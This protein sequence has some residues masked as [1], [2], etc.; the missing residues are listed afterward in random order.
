[1]SY[2]LLAG[3]VPLVILAVSSFDT[4]RRIIIQQAGQFHSQQMADLNAYLT[5]YA[6]QIESLSANIA[7]NESIGSALSAKRAAEAVPSGSFSALKTQAQIGY[8]LNSYVG[9]KGL[10]SIDL[11]SFDNRRFHVGDTLDVSEVDK[12]HLSALVDQTR[13]FDAPVYWF[14]IGDNLNRA[15]T[16]KKVL[17]MSR[18][19][20]YFEP[21]TGRAEEVGLLV[22]NI[23]AGVAV[24]SFLNEANTNHR[25]RLMLVDRNGNFIYHSDPSLLGANA[26]PALAKLLTSGSTSQTVRLDQEDVILSAVP[27]LRFGGHLAGALPRSDLIAPTIKLIYTGVALFLLGLCAIG[28]LSWRFA[29]HVVA[30]VRD[31]S[32]GFLRLQKHPDSSPKPLKVPEFKD[33]M[34]ELVI[35][36]NQYLE[37]LAAQRVAAQQLFVA[38]QAANAAAELEKRNLALS[39]EI[40]RREAAES[41][42]RNLAFFDQLT[43]LPN[44]RLLVDRLRQAMAVATRTKKYCALLFIDL[45]NF[46]TL[47]D[48]QGHNVGDLL[49]IEVS[50]R[51]SSCVREGDTVARQ[52]GDE[53]VV[54]LEDLSEDR[55]TAA[56]NAELV[57]EKILTSLNMTYELSRQP[58]HGTPSIGIT[59]FV[60]HEDAS[61]ELL[62]RAD[63]AMYQAKAAGRNTV[64]FFDAEMQT[65]IETR[66]AME[67]RLREAILTNQFE[68]YYQPQVANENSLIGAEVLIRWM[69]PKRGMVCPAEF[70]PLAEETGLILP[71]GSWVLETACAQLA[72]WSTQPKMADLTI[73]VNISARQFRSQSFTDEVLAIIAKTGAN[74]ARLKL[75]LTES[76]LLD[77]VESIIVNLE[78]LRAR[79]VSFSLDDFGTGYSSLSYLKRLPLD[80]LKIDQGFVRDVLVDVN[81]AAIAKMIVALAESLGLLV[82]AEGVE[83]E[84]QKQ[85]LSENGCHAFQGYLFGKPMPL[86]NFEQ[87]AKQMMS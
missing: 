33:E 49:L 25:L 7:G 39:Q 51:L 76:F 84:A 4:S 2:L 43:G 17:M 45:D 87:L 36:F 64:R 81:D 14:G 44:R 40:A 16:K 77:N 26:A 62:K 75:E 74:P 10:V 22:I 58:Y 11:F 61:E 6:E 65:A 50:R 28:L 48:T 9:V 32:M 63:L 21:S 86:A 19:V 73:A 60:D 66:A 3:I 20:R 57:A 30:P 56:K 53:F 1:M 55:T 79:G 29:R 82:I 8:I 71:I 67:A 85:F 31:V 46:K 35:G 27:I 15:S 23:D 24:N 78:I 80:Q 37:V 70:I 54:V 12:A 68:L 42:I 41:E 83:T 38:Q 52:G 47:N 18:V 72:A 13:K 34:A 69:D 59:L 5:V